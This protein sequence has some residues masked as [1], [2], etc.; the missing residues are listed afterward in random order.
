M[1][2]PDSQRFSLSVQI[3]EKRSNIHSGEILFQQHTLGRCL[4]MDLIGQPLLFKSKFVFEFF[5][6]TF[7]NIAKWSD[8]I[9]VYGHFDWSHCVILLCFV[10]K[11]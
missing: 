3:C 10:Y 4:G 5:D 7:A 1:V 11:S 8:I 6:N 9:R 2:K